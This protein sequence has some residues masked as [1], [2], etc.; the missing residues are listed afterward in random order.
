[1]VWIVVYD[2]PVNQINLKFVDSAH[3]ASISEVCFARGLWCFCLDLGETPARRGQRA[4]LQGIR[5]RG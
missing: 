1:M 3:G 2:I 5:A 4:G